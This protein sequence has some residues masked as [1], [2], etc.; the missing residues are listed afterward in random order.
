MLYFSISLPYS[1][2]SLITGDGSG[3]GSK[4][5]ALSLTKKDVM[6]LMHPKAVTGDASSTGTHG[7]GPH[8]TTSST[9]SSTSSTSQDC[10]NPDPIKRDSNEKE[11]GESQSPLHRALPQGSGPKDSILEFAL[12]H[13]DEKVSHH[14]IQVIDFPH[15]FRFHLHHL[16]LNF[17][18][19]PPF[20]SQILVRAELDV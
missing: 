16:C 8:P 1:L 12:T 7:K 6:Q 15:Y 10:E 4:M 2:V 20:N 3:F 13:F 19:Y 14:S 11:K 9:A 17:L 5:P 18:Y